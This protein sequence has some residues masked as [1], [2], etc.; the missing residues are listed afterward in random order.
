MVE[1]EAARAVQLEEEAA[2]R[3]AHL[4]VLQDKASTCS[5]SPL[6]LHPS[7]R[8]AC[9]SRWNHPSQS[10]TKLSSRTD[11]WYGPKDGGTTTAMHDN[12]DP[13]P[14]LVGENSTCSIP[15]L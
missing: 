14:P 15:V 5:P 3:E 7:T 10:M 2:A 11:A 8:L 4:R 9:L 6:L 12:E 13:P 1:V